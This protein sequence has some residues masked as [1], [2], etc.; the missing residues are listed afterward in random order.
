M[1]KMLAIV[2]VTNGS[3]SQMDQSFSVQLADIYL[4][5]FR[6]V[7]FFLMDIYTEDVDKVFNQ[8]VS[9]GATP[10]MPI[11]DMFLGR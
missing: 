10:V 6:S 1:Q 3:S 2:D 11:M 9:A 5:I 8:S 7:L 4:L